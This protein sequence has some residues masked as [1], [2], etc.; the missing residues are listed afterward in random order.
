MHWES[1]KWDA[2]QRRWVAFARAEQDSVRQRQLRANAERV[3]SRYES[4]DPSR[5]RAFSEQR[6]ADL[7]AR[8]S[9]LFADYSAAE[10]KVQ[11]A[12]LKRRMR[13]TD[14]RI[15]AAI[16]HGEAWRIHKAAIEDTLRREGIDVG[17]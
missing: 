5:D 8:K 13:M 7:K 6:I 12:R 9:E 3:L 10:D 14:R 17:G 1:R 16:I 15:R 2:E 11:K 4:Y